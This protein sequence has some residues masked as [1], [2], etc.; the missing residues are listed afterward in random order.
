VTSKENEQAKVKVV[1]KVAAEPDCG[2]RDRSGGGNGDGTAVDGRDEGWAG[3]R[4]VFIR[5]S[6]IRS[7]ALQDTYTK[8][9]SVF[10]YPYNSDISRSSLSLH[11]Q[12]PERL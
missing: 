12:V 2:G 1:A 10:R 11:S 7:K 9:S 4:G 6:S 8:H 3:R 5:S